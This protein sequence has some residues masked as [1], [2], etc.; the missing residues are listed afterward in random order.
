MSAA[1]FT[2]PVRQRIGWSAFPAKVQ[3]FFIRLR[4]RFGTARDASW[5][6]TGQPDHLLA[7]ATWSEIVYDPGERA[8]IAAPINEEGRITNMPGAWRHQ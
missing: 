7:Y 1:S 4:G 8:G 5:V 2:E 6:F 3:A